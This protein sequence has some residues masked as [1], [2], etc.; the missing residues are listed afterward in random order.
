[1][2]LFFHDL[3]C[4]IYTFSSSTNNFGH[5]QALSRMGS[6][7][8]RMHIARVNIDTLLDARKSNAMPKGKKRYTHL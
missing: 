7:S 1:M 3:I 6:L 8:G 2:F 5:A 4:A